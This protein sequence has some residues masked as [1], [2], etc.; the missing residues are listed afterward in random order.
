MQPGQPHSPDQSNCGSREPVQQ[1]THL[2]GM[3][4]EGSNLSWN[5]KQNLG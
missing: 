2:A 5:P 3:S 1:T 4:A